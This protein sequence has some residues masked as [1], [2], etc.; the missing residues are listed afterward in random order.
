[1][2]KFQGNPL[3]ER[4][5]KTMAHS[6]ICIKP[7]P[8]GGEMIVSVPMG[9]CSAT[10]LRKRIDSFNPPKELRGYLPLEVAVDSQVRAALERWSRNKGL[11]IGKTS[12]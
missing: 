5:L 8:E 9:R 6:V 12:A 7:A 11:P 4:E 2:S 10:A 1:M 3:R